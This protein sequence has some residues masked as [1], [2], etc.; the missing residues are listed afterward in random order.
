MFWNINEQIVERRNAAISL[1]EKRQHSDGAAE[2]GAGLA[3]GYLAEGLAVDAMVA[4]A[5]SLRS[6]PTAADFCWCAIE[7]LFDERLFKSES[8]ARLH[9]RLVSGRL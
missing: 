5:L 6:G 7:V 9:D 3:I 2:I 8:S 1:A 4:A